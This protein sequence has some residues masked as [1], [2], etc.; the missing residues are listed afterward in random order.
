M[1]TLSVAPLFGRTMRQLTE[2]ITIDADP[3]TVWSVLVDT[4]RYREWNPLIRYDGLVREGARPRVRLSLPGLPAIYTRPRI[5]SVEFERELR[6]RTRFPA[7]TATHSFLLDGPTDGIDHGT[8]D[9]TRLV[10]TERFDGSLAD[11]IVKRFER[12]SVRGFRQMNLGLKRRAERF[13]R[14]EGTPP[15]DDDSV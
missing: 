10:Q 4:D 9:R 15:C 7:L 5:L 1:G 12:A 13:A 14:D 8:D 2:A 6:W 3:E 11:P